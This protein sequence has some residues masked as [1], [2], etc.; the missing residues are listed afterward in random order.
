MKPIKS[1]FLNPGFSLSFI[2][3]LGL[4]LIF[5]NAN[6]LAK[7]P[8]QSLQQESANLKETIDV[9]ELPFKN[10]TSAFNVMVKEKTPEGVLRLVL[11]NMYDKRIT[12]FKTSL[13]ITSSLVDTILSTHDEGIYPGATREE[14]FPIDIDPELESKGIA[15]LAV[16]FEDGTSDGHP[17]FVKEI[18]DYRLGQKLQVRHVV[19]KLNQTLNL[20]DDEIP[21]AL[22]KIQSGMLSASEKRYSTL[23]LFARFGIGDAEKRISKYIENIK[24]KPDKEI[25]SK[26]DALIDYSRSKSDE[27]KAYLERAKVR[28]HR[29]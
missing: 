17:E 4:M 19:S 23:P 8:G 2:I 12:A 25:R 10:H 11:Q 9:N 24:G 13:G 21:E 5:I 20:P 28:E 22:T 6:P 16:T 27:L 15:I 14:F 7:P 18:Q 26:L 1:S 29:F 3:I